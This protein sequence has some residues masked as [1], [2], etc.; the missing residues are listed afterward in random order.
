[1]VNYWYV[2][3]CAIRCSWYGV[4]IGWLFIVCGVNLCR[5]YMIVDIF[6]SLVNYCITT[7]CF[8]P[9]IFASSE[10]IIFNKIKLK[11]K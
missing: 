8:L 9:A 3:M 6:V 4:V 1:M 5:C 10:H 2:S 11:I 7:I